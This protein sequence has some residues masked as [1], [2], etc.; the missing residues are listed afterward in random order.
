MIAPVKARPQDK[1]RLDRL[2]A[3]LTAHSGR[4][5]S[6]EELLARLLGLVERERDALVDEIG[7]PMSQ[8]EIDTL[9]RLPV[10]TG[11]RTREKDI[12]L[13]LYGEER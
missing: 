7:R 1:Q 8:K 13:D 9:L 5:I 2:Q 10:R 4:R 12:D 11:V 3:L 6:Q